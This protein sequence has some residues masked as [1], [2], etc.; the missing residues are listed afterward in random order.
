MSAKKAGHF[1]VEP[2]IIYPWFQRKNFHSGG[3]VLLLFFHVSVKA[4]GEKKMAFIWILD[5]PTYVM[6]VG[7][8]TSHQFK[9]HRLNVIT[10]WCQN[11]LTG[12]LLFKWLLFY[13]LCVGSV[14]PGC[15][16]QRS[17]RVLA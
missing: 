2:Y 17:E 14:I 3:L 5:V 13:P 12:E 1:S 7:F 4:V 15:H 6:L 11:F 8:A 16:I 10:V 9:A